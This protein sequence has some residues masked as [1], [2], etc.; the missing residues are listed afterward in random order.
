MKRIG[1][2][3]LAAM[4]LPE[5]ARNPIML[6]GDHGPVAYRNIYIKPLD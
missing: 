1:G 5:A 4:Q 2:G 3:I 6:Q